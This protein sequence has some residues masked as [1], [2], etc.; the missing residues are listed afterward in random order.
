M[1]MNSHI[2]ASP[3][4]KVRRLQVEDASALAAFYNRLSKESKR[5]FRPIGPITIPE[6]CLEIAADNGQEES[7]S[8]K[9]DLIAV[10]DGQIIGWGFIWN[11][12][13]TEPTFGLAVADAYHHRG[14]GN[15]LMSCTM[16]WARNQALKAVHLTVVQDNI[17]A[18]KLY[19][20][21]GFVKENEFIGE[22]GQPYYSMVAALSDFEQ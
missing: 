20:K 21:Y 10:Y 6:K 16:Q 7:A 12:T 9:Y 13:S 5:T 11:L 14:V 18:W 15:F 22:D 17:I 8:S 3:A 2:T 1:E 19:E 4:F